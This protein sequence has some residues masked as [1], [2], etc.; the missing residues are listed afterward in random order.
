MHH[1]LNNLHPGQAATARNPKT[2]PEKRNSEVRSDTP[3]T[4]L[5]TP[6]TVSAK[7][8]PPLQP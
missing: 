4:S 2:E 5:P 7:P 8:T 3:P 1:E 6:I